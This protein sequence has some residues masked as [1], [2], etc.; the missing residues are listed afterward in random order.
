MNNTCWEVSDIKGVFSTKWQ[1]DTFYK[2]AKIIKK[3][4]QPQ[5]NYCE[6][7]ARFLL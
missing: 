2:H 4:P 3:I 7:R 5:M 6:K 1:N